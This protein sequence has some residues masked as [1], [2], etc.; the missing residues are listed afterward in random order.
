MSCRHNEGPCHD[1][2]Y[3]D[4]RNALIPLAEAS[5]DVE[6]GGRFKFHRESDIWAIKWS[7]AFHRAMTRL[8]KGVFQ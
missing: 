8:M 6:C 1:C 2:S 7:A 5:A 3:V 4:R